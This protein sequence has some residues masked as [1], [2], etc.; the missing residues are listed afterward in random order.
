MSIDHDT[1]TLNAMHVLPSIVTVLVY[2]LPLIFH[3]VYMMRP[4]M[5]G[6]WKSIAVWFSV[7]FTSGYLNDN[8]KHTY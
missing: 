4:P 3:M 2:R 5:Q 7:H 6:V 8:H 1:S